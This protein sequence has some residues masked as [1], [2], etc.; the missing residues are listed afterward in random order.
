[1]EIAL[2]IGRL[3]LTGLLYL[4]LMAVFVV[5]WRDMRAAAPVSLPP[6]QT[7][8]GQL[9]VLEGNQDIQAGA[10]LSLQPFTTLGRGAANTIVVPDTFASAEHA[11][12][13]LRGGQWWLEDRGS[14]NGTTLND[15]RIE[16]PV[17]LGD[18]DVIGIGR[19]K[20]RVEIEN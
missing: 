4:F 11:I 8:D 5:L 18:S 2:F 12:I 13:A 15:V 10:A 20:L 7:P 17:V 9:I 19:V 3:V 16:A 1:M 14:R 6:A